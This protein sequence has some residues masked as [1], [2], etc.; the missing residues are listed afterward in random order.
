MSAIALLC[1]ATAAV[2]GPRPP[3]HY[4]FRAVCAPAPQVSGHIDGQRW[5]LPGVVA[6]VG[7]A[8]L[9]GSVGMI[10]AASIVGVTVAWSA[11]AAMRDRA[12]LTRDDELLQA[13]GVV[14]AELS[15]GSPTA[16]ACARASAELLADD[17]S[18]PVGR[19]LSVLAARVRLGGD[20]APE[21]AGSVHRIASLWAS[22]ARYGLPLVDLLTASRSDLLARQRFAA[23]T[24]A[25]L[26]GPRATARV[27]AILPV[28]GLIL[29]QGIGADPLRVLLAPGVGSV[30]MIVGTALAAAGVVWS[31]KIVA[32]VLR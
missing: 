24:R 2:V 21:S 20:I 5:V 29:G 22:A 19:H 16:L 7:V 17:P 14:I 31:E 9:T 18:S 1:L 32:S 28:F 25:G 6:V 3:A 12:E 30:L 23:R 27:L 11:R 4:R 10:V 15:V 8:A 13:I 26:A